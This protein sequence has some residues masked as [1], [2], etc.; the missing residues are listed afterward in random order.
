MSR[1]IGDTKCCLC[2]G[3]INLTE[4]TRA[5]RKEDSPAYWSEYA[6]MIVAH[7]KC[8]SCHAQYIAWMGNIPGQ[9]DTR[10]ELKP[11]VEILDLSYRST[12]N[13]EAGPEDM[14][15]VT[16][17]DKLRTDML[18]QFELWFSCN[19]AEQPDGE[20]C[21]S[22]KLTFELWRSSQDDEGEPVW[23]WTVGVTRTKCQS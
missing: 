14:P 23:D 13:D 20:R 17:T 16:L 8:V 5:F 9:P 18:K 3:Q 2:S 21:E 12:F 4:P 6:D 1:N 7:A 10:I 19:V 15:V 22:S 11:P